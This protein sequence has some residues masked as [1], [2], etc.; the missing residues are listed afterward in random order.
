MRTSSI[1]QRLYLDALIS[2]PRTSSQK[3]PPSIGYQKILEN[4]AR[5]PEFTRRAGELLAQD[6]LK[7]AE[8]KKFDPAHP[9]IYPTGKLPQKRLVGMERNVYNLIVKRFLAVFGEPALRQTV[10]VVVNLNG[11]KFLLNGR[12]TLKE[13]WLHFYEGYARMKDVPLPPVM[14]GQEVAVRK[15]ALE[16]KFTQPPPRYNPSSLLRKMEQCNIGTKA[17]RAGITQTL[18]D[19]KYIQQ[20]KMAVSDLGLQVTDVLSKFC[21]SVVSVE[22]TRMLEEKMSLVQTGQET[23]QKIISEAIEL[24]KPVMASLEKNEQAVGEQLSGAIQQVHLE[25]R[26]IGACPTCKDGKLIIQHS[27]KTG[28]RFVGCTNY[29]NGT[30]KTAF[31]LPQSGFV[32]PSGKTCRGCGW[33]TVLV[34]LKRKRPWNLCI[35]PKC[36]TK[37]RESS[38]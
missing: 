12:R 2:Y 31:P 37:K 16:D 21:P 23:K 5:N 7:P 19:R 6:Q 34:W 27:K 29:F 32:K 25:E 1:A 3:L 17:T 4:L 22:F 33:S 28:K 11:E 9:A 38:K 36:P 26:I 15:V 20:E 24:L 10:K 14:E 35:N 30:C 8:G 13:G 18:Y